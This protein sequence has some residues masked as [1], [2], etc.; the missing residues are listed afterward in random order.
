MFKQ[1]VAITGRN[2]TVPPCSVGPRTGH[3]AGP[4]TADARYRRRQTTSTDDDD[5]RQSTPTDDSVQNNI[6]PL[7]G[8]VIMQW[9]LIILW[10]IHGWKT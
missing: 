5:R 10:I 3:A 4:A 6:D 7:G 9:R 1:G 2:R 8:P